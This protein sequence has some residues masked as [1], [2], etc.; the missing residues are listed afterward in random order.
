MAITSS[1]K[2]FDTTKSFK[3]RS[4]VIRRKD[5][6]RSFAILTNPSTLTTLSNAFARDILQL[7]LENGMT[8]IPDRQ[9]VWINLR[10]FRNSG[11]ERFWLKKIGSSFPDDAFGDS[12]EI[13]CQEKVARTIRT[14]VLCSHANRNV[15]TKEFGGSSRL[16]FE[17]VLE[18][19]D[20]AGDIITIVIAPSGLKEWED[21][22][23]GLGILYHLG[24][25]TWENRWLQEILRLVDESVADDPL[26]RP[27]GMTIREYVARLFVAIYMKM[28]NEA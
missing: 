22:A 14:G 21:L 26:S 10:I 20:A 23:L 4:I 2:K 1:N 15:A 6:R 7:M 8:M 27:Q 12:C 24:L 3:H 16:D 18:R 28:K 5:H 19:G 11:L 25:V 9:A 17:L 13:F